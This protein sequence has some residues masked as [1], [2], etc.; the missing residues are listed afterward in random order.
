[1]F[2][3]VKILSTKSK[4]ENMKNKISIAALFLFI[5]SFAQGQ[6]FILKSDGTAIKGKVI[7]LQNNRLV[8]LQ[9]DETEIILSRKAVISIIF[10]YPI[11]DATTSI[12]DI[13]STSIID[14]PAGM[15]AK[16]VEQPKIVEAPL[17][18]KA[19]AAVATPKNAI[20]SPGDVSGLDMRTLISAPALKQGAVGVGRVAVNVCLNSE[21]QVI[22]AKFKAVGSTT[23]DADLISLAVQNAKEFKFS[24]GEANECGTITYRFNLD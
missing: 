15:T 16:A 22:T 17:Q 13:K 7:S 9:E 1:L 5:V 3:Y 21:G 20:E 8:V 6:D 24:K 23:V 19:P 12:N 18:I 11:N 10:D 14:P 4:K 2:F